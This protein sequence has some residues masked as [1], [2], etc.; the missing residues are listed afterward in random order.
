MKVQELRDQRVALTKQAQGILDKASAEKRELTT[1][2]DEQ[3]DKIWGEVDDKKKEIDTAEKAERA[4]GRNAEHRARA[5]REAADLAASAGRSTSPDR[6]DR[7]GDSATGRRD[8]RVEFEFRG[9]QVVFEPGTPEHRRAQPAARTAFREY[10]GA[11]TRNLQSDLDVQGGFLRAPEQFVA[12]LIT[13]LDDE[14]YM[15]SLCRRFTITADTA[16]APRRTNKLSTF[17]WGQELTAPVGDT[18]L[19][20]GKRKFT[21]HY[22]TGEIT[23]SRD[24]L[25]AAIMDPEAIVM[26]ELARDS[27]ELEENAFL[28]GSGAAQPLGIF[29]ASADGISTARDVSADN[30]AT[31]LTWDGL[32]NVQCSLKQGYQK[33]ATWMFHRD[34]IRNVRKLKDAEN[35]YL[36]E[37]STKVGEP[38]TIL[39]KPYISSEWCPNTF[40]TGQ[41]VGM[42]GDFS[43]YWIFD[44]LF[45]QMQMLVEA[46][47]RT[48]EVSWV[49]R[50]KVDGGPAKEEAFARIKLP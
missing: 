24:L 43:Q 11:E 15:R 6:P 48:N 3:L 1:A 37:A 28:F 31:A 33:N 22:M 9:R 14:V 13:N 2:E 4:A 19:K 30:T 5:E 50:R 41:Y 26:D 44:T 42:Y 36:W 45:L 16:G 18:S 21:P 7:P 10:L 27:G 39:G 34:G 12:E 17:R 38:D 23:V 47:A 8:G 32:I 25:F 49:V 40:T 20:F 46:G 35:R 29:T